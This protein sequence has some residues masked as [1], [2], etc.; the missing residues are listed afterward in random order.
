MSDK[1]IGS[2]I[3]YFRKF[4][5]FDSYIR[6]ILEDLRKRKRKIRVIRR[7]VDLPANRTIFEKEKKSVPLISLNYPVISSTVT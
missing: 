5:G 4:Q 2:N 3:E 1:M 6:E 7:S